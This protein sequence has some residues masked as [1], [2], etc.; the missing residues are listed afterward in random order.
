MTEKPPCRKTLVYCNFN[1]CTD[2][3]IEKAASD[4]PWRVSSNSQ[5]CHIL[6][7]SNNSLEGSAVIKANVKF[8]TFYTFRVQ[9]VSISLFGDLN[10]KLR[11]WPLLK[12]YRHFKRLNVK[13]IV[14]IS[15][16]QRRHRC[17][18]HKHADAGVSRFLNDW[19]ERLKSSGR[20]AHFRLHRRGV[21]LQ[22]SSRHS[23]Y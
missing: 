4:T 22:I 12:F 15:E 2:I 7:G 13:Q 18:R 11:S 8:M 21:W 6:H 17:Q 3:V 23:S 14:F 10:P 9:E 19:W 20:S 1:V 16:I 5:A